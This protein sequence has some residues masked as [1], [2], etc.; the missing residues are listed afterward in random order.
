MKYIKVVFGNKGAN[1]EY[2]INEVNVANNWNPNA[3]SGKDFGGFNFSTEDKI[4]RW[5]HRGD[6]L[7][8]VIIPED[9]EV[10]NIIESATP[11]GVFRSNK[12]IL[13]N[14][15]KMTDDIAMYFYK[16]SNIPDIAYYKA[17]GAVA[18]MGYDKTA[19]QILRDKVNK[20]NIDVVLEEWNDFIYKKGRD[21]MNETT[22]FIDKVLNEIEQGIFPKELYNI[23]NTTKDEIEKEKL[24]NRYLSEI[25]NEV[26]EIMIKEGLYQRDVTGKIFPSF[27]SCHRRWA[28]EKS[29]LKERYNFDWQTPEEKNSFIDYD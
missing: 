22:R 26:D 9:A 8:D 19:K 27:G 2:K 21:I 12:I 10:V 16:K 24:A 1:C 6:T 11:N 29:I 15:R 25:S 3:K 17:M 18:I 20:E 28:I 4:I 13:T 23:H 14:P 7:Y 5:L